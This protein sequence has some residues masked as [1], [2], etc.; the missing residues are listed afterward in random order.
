MKKH[1]EII[2]GILIILAVVCLIITVTYSIYI[3]QKNQ[4]EL[5]HPD[6]VYGESVEKYSYKEV[7]EK[8]YNC[9]HDFIILNEEGFWEIEKRCVGY[10][11]EDG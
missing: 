1:T 6:Q 2:I 10:V 4:F 5:C 11:K 7:D 9:C 8:H 3:N